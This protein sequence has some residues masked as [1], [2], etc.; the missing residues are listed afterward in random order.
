MEYVKQNFEKG[1]VLTADHMNYIEDGI[2]QNTDAMN[3]FND[4]LKNYYTKEEVDNKG[5]LTEHQ[6]L[7]GYYTKEE[8]DNKGY[9]TGIPSGYATEEYVTNTINEAIATVLEAEY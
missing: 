1:Q 7:S 6:D 8:V 2:V 5:Y 9:L 3:D 4:N